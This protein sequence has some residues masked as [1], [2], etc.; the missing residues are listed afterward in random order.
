MFKNICD[1]E[2]VERR[3]QQKKD[4]GKQRE[5]ENETERNRATDRQKHI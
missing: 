5:I 3:K 2:R 4:L 1:Y